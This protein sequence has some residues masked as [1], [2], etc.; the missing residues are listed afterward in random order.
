MTTMPA[1]YAAKQALLHELQSPQLLPLMLDAHPCPEW[2]QADFFFHPLGSVDGLALAHLLAPPGYT[3]LLVAGEM[4]AHHQ[5]VA[6]GRAVRL[7][8][9]RGAMLWWQASHGPEPRR[10]AAGDALEL[11]PYEEHGF[12]VLEDVLN[13]NLLSPCA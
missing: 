3:A 4:G 10:V 5:R 7:H 12:V 13:Y 11:A 6:I 9:L 1:A 2:V 8:V